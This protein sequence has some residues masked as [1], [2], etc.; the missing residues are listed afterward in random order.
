[1]LH[2]CIVTQNLSW[3]HNQSLTVTI[4]KTHSCATWHAQR[5]ISSNKST[6]TLNKT[7]NCLFFPCSS[8]RSSSPNTQ[9]P[10]T[11]NFHC[12]P[13]ECV[14]NNMCHLQ[15]KCEAFLYT[16]RW[17]DSLGGCNAVFRLKI[18]LWYDWKLWDGVLYVNTATVTCGGSYCHSI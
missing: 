1:M 7:H 4:N 17:G 6:V 18:A 9:V 14:D 12:W 5:R 2:P 11:T 3:E 15:Y 10:V 16:C 8:G 13:E